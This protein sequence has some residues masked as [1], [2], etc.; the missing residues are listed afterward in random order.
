MS[1][2]IDILG[3]DGKTVELPEPHQLAGGTYA[4]GG[5]TSLSFNVTYNYGSI[6]RRVLN[7]EGIRWLDGQRVANTIPDL[8]SAIDKLADDT[9]PDY[10]K[11]TE[12]NVKTA[13][14]SLL[15]LGCKC[16]QGRWSVR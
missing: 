14:T 13:L 5:T 3:P 1:F 11:A 7:P 16:P 4:L 10:W 9:D 6:I 8:Y 12:G 2:D 15:V